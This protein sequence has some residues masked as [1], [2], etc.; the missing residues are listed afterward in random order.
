MDFIKANARGIV[1]VLLAAGVIATLSSGS[2]DLQKSSQDSEQA[3]AVPTETSQQNTTQDT[4]QQT[5]QTTAS[6]EE[7][8][9][10]N[11]NYAVVAAIN[12]NQTKLTR[13]IVDS[14]QSGTSE[15]LS[16]EQ[17]LYIVTTIV[18]EDLKRNDLIHIGDVLEVKVDKLKDTVEASKLLTEVQVKYWAAYL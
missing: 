4:A 13:R 1:L 17:R 5:Q 15:V 3:N 12:D 6:P 16:A 14:Y 18:N 9:I 7:I 10:I 2:K 11:N 8:K